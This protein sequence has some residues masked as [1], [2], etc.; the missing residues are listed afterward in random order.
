MPSVTEK[1]EYQIAEVNCQG[2]RVHFYVLALI[3]ASCPYSLA[4]DLEMLSDSDTEDVHT[5]NINEHYA[6]AFEYKR[7]REELSKCVYRSCLLPEINV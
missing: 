4:V 5:L 6:R 1:R 7:E 3:H 2:S